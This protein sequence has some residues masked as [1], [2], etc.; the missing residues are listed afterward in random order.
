MNT[1]KP[2]KGILPALTLATAFSPYLLQAQNTNKRPN[3][4][5]FLMDDLGSSDV[6]FSQCKDFQTPHIDRIAHEGVQCTNAYICATYSGPSRSGLNTG[7]YQQRFG[8]EMNLGAEAVNKKGEPLGVPLDELMLS[9]LL[10]NHGYTTCGI[11]KW[12]LGDDPRL[13]PNKRGF[14]YFYGF[15]GG[16]F[17]Y[18]GVRF[19]A[20]NP[21]QADNFIQ[22]N[23]VEVP[24]A[25]TTYLT[26]DFTDKTVD[27]INRNAKNEKPMYLYVSYNAPHGPYQAPQKYL[28][29][30]KH[31]FNAH[32]SVYAA[33]VLA[34]DDGIGRI[35]QALE[36]NGVAENT[37]MIFLSD[38]GGTADAMNYP[39]RAFKGNM[40]DG[41]TYTPFAMRWPGHIQ[42]GMKY[43][44]VISSLDIFP[45]VAA[46]AGIDTQKAC[47]KELDGVDLMPY[48]TGSNTGE[49]NHELYWRVV[50]GLE[51]AARI[52]NY[53][54]IKRYYQ[55]APLLFDMKN[56]PIEQ[57][58]IAAEHPTL[59]KKMMKAYNAW[60]KQL[61]PARWFDTHELH[62]K[63][64]Y[65]KWKNF[66]KTASFKKIKNE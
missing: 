61:I 19:T 26:D 34:A 43:D 33:M 23:G 53:K 57:Y 6:S 32:R 27:F 30:T 25:K 64:D 44:K 62:Q 4:V 46:A 11:G 48:I 2:L 40:F 24:E 29:R 17:D 50:N 15:S 45:T 41:G 47:Q 22:E 28:D 52:G 14:D 56:D 5:V 58:D 42:P 8:A 1:L 65:T 3:I 10:H 49:P 38:N 7:R 13:W 35:Q 51:Y 54:M 59:I 12:H 9:E 39:R 55:E 36:E 16:H 37:L 18:W 63:Q 21:R 20:K 66:R 60:D 31:I